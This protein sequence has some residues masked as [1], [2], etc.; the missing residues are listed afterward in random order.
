[1]TGYRIIW[2]CAVATLSAAGALI[3]V[4]LIAPATMIAVFVSAALVCSLATATVF[5]LRD[6]KQHGLLRRYARNALLGGAAGIAATGLAEV[7]GGF[8]ILIVL[9]VVAASPPAV[10]W[11]AAWLGEH[12]PAHSSSKYPE[13]KRHRTLSI[14]ELCT[15]WTQGCLDLRGATPAQALRFVEAR[16]YYLDEL[17]RRDPDGLRAWLATA[18]SASGSPRRFISRRTDGC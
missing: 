4:I 3:A 12:R 11:Y 1:M 10:R 16:Q 14:E 2:R 15:A 18:A 6:E 17:E 13:A 8:A 5:A 7:V 9:V